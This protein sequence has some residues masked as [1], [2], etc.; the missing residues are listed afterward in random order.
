MTSFLQCDMWYNI[1][2]EGATEETCSVIWRKSLLM[3]KICSMLRV[4]Y[5]PQ[6]KDSKLPLMD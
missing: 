1:D 3:P 5:T 2:K 6:V 4:N